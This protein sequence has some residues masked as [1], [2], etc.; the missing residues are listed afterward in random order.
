MIIPPRFPRKTNQC[1]RCKLR[2]LYKR[3]E[4]CP[5]CSEL[6]DSGLQ[7]LSIR[8]KEES[9]TNAALGRKM[10]PGA[11]LVSLAVIIL[12]ALKH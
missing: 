12:V 4:Q 5:H 8:I 10:I 7:A 1:D 6:D 2:Y 9:I 11:V 3:Y